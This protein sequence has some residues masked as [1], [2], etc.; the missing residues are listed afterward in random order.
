[1]TVQLAVV[2]LLVHVL[3]WHYLV[4]TA[5][6][7]EAAVLH[8]F[9][10][11]QRWTW[12][13][14]PA[15]SRKIAAIRFTQFHLLNGFVS[16]AGNLGL[17]ALGTGIFRLDAVAANA[18]AIVACSL[19]NFAAS[20][21]IVF[22]TRR[23]PSRRRLWS[24]LSLAAL[25]FLIMPATANAG[26]S[27]S[28]LAGWR[29]YEAEIES[30]YSGATAS[31]AN[32]FF[33]LDRD[34][35]SRGWRDEVLH[36]QPWLIK[37]DAPTVDDGK[38]HHWVGAIFVPGTTV[39]ALIDRLKRDA[40]H[41]FEHYEDVIASRL[42]ER[43]GDRLRVFMK[44]RRTNLI[45]VMYNTEHAVEYRRISDTRA[46]ARS[47]ATRIAELEDAG[48]A[49]EH[50][51]PAADDNGFLWRLNAYWRY[52]QV[53]GGVIVECESVS[54]S[55]PVPLLIR[56]VANPIVDRIARESLDRTL[57]SLRAVL[58]SKNGH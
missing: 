9:V 11:H 16:L 5:L 27:P 12:R 13:D 3:R 1:M 21:A 58:T 57:F 22:T 34:P 42:I 29:A 23:L 52:E 31:A 8:N 47:V 46:S 35:R 32:P 25:M 33:V 7:V 19:V 36:G 53:E 37:I 10:W 39:Q 55:R 28:A 49:Q 44:L 20:E 24:S 50:E 18:I 51:K 4:A 48:T 17:T 6:A 40:G 41:E 30:R 43:S 54:L 56:P 26:P 14:R 2:A 45:T 15:P 38:I